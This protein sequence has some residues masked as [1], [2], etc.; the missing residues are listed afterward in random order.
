MDGISM[1]NYKSEMTNEISGMRK[2]YR[3]KQD[4]FDL[5]MLVSKEPFGQFEAWFN[6]AKNTDGIL[7][8]NAMSIATATKDGKPSVRM[9]LMKGIDKTGIVFF[10]NFL[11]QK[12]KELAENPFCSVLFYWEPLKRQIRVEGCVE[13]VSDEESTNYFHS[14]PRDSQIGACV[15]QQ[16]QVTSSRKVIDERN[17]ELQEKFSDPNVL[18]PKP[19]YWGG[20]RI[21][22]NKFEFWQGQSNRLHDRI[23]FR[24][25]K[26]GEF[27]DPA[28]T[29]EGIDGWVYE[30]LMP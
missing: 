25:L 19:D 26:N 27:L 6:E 17:E 10:T 12:A 3:S 21:I 30:R 2:P 4:I 8:A 23:V 16:S 15:S 29:H 24:K 18:V 20:Y 28:V 9:V 22:P 14:R 5:D 1:S 13:K 11:S 7:E